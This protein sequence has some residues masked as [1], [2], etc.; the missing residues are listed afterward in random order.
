MRILQVVPT[1]LPAVRYGGP[2]FAVHGLCR[3]LAEKGHDVVVFTTNVDGAGTSDVPLDQPV[4]LD[5]VQIRYFPSPLL[6]RL[7]RAPVLG[8]ALARDVAGFDVVHLHSVFLWPVWAAARAARK[9]QVPYVMSPRGMLVK[10][11]IQRHSRWAKMAWIA[12]IEKSNLETASAIHVTSELERAELARFHWRL[13]PVV[14]IPNGVDV[15]APDRSQ[16][17]A[18][19]RNVCAHQPLV[20]FLGRLSWKKG[21]DR[22]LRAFALTR[23]GTLVI[24]GTDDE[25]MM[26]RLM[27]QVVQLKLEDRVCFLPRT[28]SGADKERLYASARIFV[29]PSYS[30]NFGNTVLEAMCRGI[31]V[32]VT[33]DVGAATIVEQAGAGLTVAGMPIDIAA[34]IDRLIADP[35]LARAMGEA[36]RGF[37]LRHYGWP[38]IAGKMAELY[39][40]IAPV[41]TA[42]P[43]FASAGIAV[44]RSGVEI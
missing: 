31:P 38:D 42:S 40:A 21:I 20:L 2:I 22:L 18:D 6:R 24:A 30:E 16:A 5:G 35:L 19:V 28:V 8:R 23:A 29:L 27:P 44:E 34:A 17:S 43:E 4:W 37:V 25:N 9:A 33:A 41:A 15:P 10:D 7:Y 3:A 36:G 26:D 12:L 1:Y 11:L 13:P 39:A 14:T 32:V